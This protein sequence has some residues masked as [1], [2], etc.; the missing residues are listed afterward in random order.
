MLTVRSILRRKALGIIQIRPDATVF[1]G[2]SLMARYDVGA[3]LVMTGRRLNGIF[4]ERDYARKVILYGRSSRNLKVRDIMTTEVFCVRPDQT[5]KHC[6]DMMTDF[7]VRYLP[8]VEGEV[9]GVISIGDVV[10]AVIEDQLFEIEQ[11]HT[12][13]GA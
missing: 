8:V 2:L 13:I 4:T 3:L 12:Y 9:L 7:R 6:M 10:A 11:L 5:A 1:E